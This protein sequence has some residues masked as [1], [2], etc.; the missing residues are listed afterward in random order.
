MPSDPRDL[1][2]G[3]KTRPGS[4]APSQPE[5][6]PQQAGPWL[7]NAEQLRQQLGVHPPYAPQYP[8]QPAPP[9]A[10]PPYAA[11]PYAQ[12]PYA[13][14][15][16]AAPPSAQPPYAAPPQP[17]QPAPPYAQP[18]YAAP[19]YAAP[20]Y[21]APA[22]AQPSYAQPSYAQ[23]AYAQ[24]PY[25]PPVYPARRT[26]LAAAVKPP[27]GHGFVAMAMLSLR[28]ALRLRIDANEV[29]EDERTAMLAAQ[30]AITDESQQAF[31]AWRRS[32]LFVAALLMVPVAILHAIDNTNFEDNTP[33][34]W[35]TLAYIQVMVEVVF[36]V[37]LWTQVGKW[38]A[39]RTQSRRIAWGW[40]L[41]FLTPFLVFLYPFASAVN[42]GEG[43]TRTAKM[44]VGMAIGAQAFLSLAP[45]IIS[46]LQ[47]LI[48]ASIAT[49]TLFPG[50]SAPGW[51]MVIAAPL[52]MIIF[53]VFVLLPYHFT[54]SGL[55]V[56][57]TLLVLTAKGTLVRAGL[58]LTRPM[59][60]DVARKATQRAQ[61]LWMA[62]LVAGIG[63]IVGGL[64]EL[65][66]KASPVSLA[67]FALSMG[68]NIMLLT[69]IATDALIT[70]LDRARG[71]T[72]DEQALAAEAQIEI[73]GFTA[74]RS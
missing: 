39:W 46:L 32:V 42:Y 68:A 44:A 7:G 14:P 20:A 15:A 16:Y 37:F 54:D 29:L 4:G 72:A 3:A 67:T 63:C 2:P 11:P 34:I 12:Q 59:T 25:Q 70:G 51:M 64:W 5:A 38:R 56:L 57:G 22:Y 35:K 8:A 43:D 52:Y 66:E 21:A 45:K 9:Y 41:Y 1:P 71:V 65:I 17:S 49:K 55:V 10:Q 26:H 53:Y 62:L 74:L 48:R 19:A 28:R 6:Q 30:P 60:D 27:S 36:A 58:A 61:T 23:P 24:Q 31:M 13:A 47:G 50:A 73:A 40:L 69:L 18:A 33:E